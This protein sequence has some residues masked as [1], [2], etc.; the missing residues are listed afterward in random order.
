MF[1]DAEGVG[2]RFLSPVESCD[3]LA[4]PSQCSPNVC[5]RGT[6]VEGANINLTRFIDTT[7]L[8]AS[9]VCSVVMFDIFA[10]Y[11]TGLDWI[12]SP[13]QKVSQYFLLFFWI[14]V[15][16]YINWL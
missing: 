2:F 9:R 12:S 1:L 13:H 6:S 16:I 5:K 11:E 7:H 10:M 3:L 15:Y 8:C 4:I 14:N